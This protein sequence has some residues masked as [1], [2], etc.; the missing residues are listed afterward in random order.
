MN[1][2][3]QE[4]QKKK[5]WK[6]IVPSN[7]PHSWDL[8]KKI[9]IFKKKMIFFYFN[10]DDFD[11]DKSQCSLYTCVPYGYGL[12]NFLIFRFQFWI[13]WFSFWQISILIP[14]WGTIHDCLFFPK[15]QAPLFFPYGMEEIGKILEPISLTLR[16]GRM[17]WRTRVIS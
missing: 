10:F 7:P 4:N 17:D 1:H 13:F 15:N 8:E 11:F 9:K 14:M 6:K 16:H 2:S 12:R 3:E 5:F